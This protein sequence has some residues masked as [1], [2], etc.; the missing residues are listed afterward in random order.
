MDSSVTA[1][2]LKQEG[3]EVVGF[4]FVTWHDPQTREIADHRNSQ[5]CCSLESFQDARNVA[6]FLNI[7]FHLI[8]IQDIFK[9][10]IVDHYLETYQKAETPNPCARCNKYIKF[11]MLLDTMKD[12][13]CDYMAT[14]HF[15]KKVT[16]NGQHHVMRPKDTHKDQTYF[17]YH[18]TQEKLEHILWPLSE[19]TK[20]DV[21]NMAREMNLP[22]REKKESQDICFVPDKKQEDFLK[23]HLL[24]EDLRPGPIV[25]VKGET[26]SET[27]RGL[28]LYT[29]GQ[30][31]GLDIGGLEEPHYVIAHDYGNNT[32]II[33][34][35]QDTYA[36]SLIAK[37]LNFIAEKPTSPFE[38]DVKIRY[39]MPFQKAQVSVNDDTME[40]TFNSPIR[41]VT[42]GQVAALYLENELL[43]GGIIC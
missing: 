18:L 11:G 5:S 17:M 29:I 9:E 19:Y 32:L 3:Y 7:P 40:I 8:R 4:M 43:G 31:K 27:H 23:R 25:T 16:K 15:C 20:D 10:T 14:G 37:K 28:P 42:P 41:G 6:D 1:A 2:L 12:L 30:R 39:R 24:P 34:T 35:E 38:A 36:N 21:K 22:I 33:G 26:L 13:K